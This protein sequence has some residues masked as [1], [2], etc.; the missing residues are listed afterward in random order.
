MGVSSKTDEINQICTCA[1]AS[2]IAIVDYGRESVGEW[3]QGIF[4]TRNVQCYHSP[5]P[6]LA[7]WLAELLQ[8]FGFCSIN[9]DRPC[10]HNGSVIY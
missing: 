6:W 9:F 7:A 3:I 8:H 10:G 5:F 1:G 2:Y 4:E